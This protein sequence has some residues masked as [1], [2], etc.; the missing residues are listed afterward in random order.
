MAISRFPRLGNLLF[1]V[2][3]LSVICGL[4]VLVFQ[5]SLSQV[6]LH[7]WMWL[8]GCLCFRRL[9]P[10]PF[11]ALGHERLIKT[12]RRPAVAKPSPASGN[13]RSACIL[14]LCNTS[15]MCV[16]S[17]A[18]T[19]PL[20]GRPAAG[21]LQPFARVALCHWPLNG[22]LSRTFY[23]GTQNTSNQSRNQHSSRG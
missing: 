7:P 6:M 12:R 8:F 15:S 16:L 13:A 19:I 1:S 18:L 5:L 9:G 21:R 17:Q 11:K 3:G 10:A 23:L 4:G 14:L 22:R 20:Q 2:F